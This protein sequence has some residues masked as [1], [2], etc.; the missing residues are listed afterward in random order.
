MTINLEAYRTHIEILTWINILI[1]ITE[2]WDGIEWRK[3]LILM[4]RL[5][6]DLMDAQIM[7]WAAGTNN[8]TRGAYLNFIFSIM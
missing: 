6:G 5:A 3:I 4:L 1:S 8:D 2:I 7:P